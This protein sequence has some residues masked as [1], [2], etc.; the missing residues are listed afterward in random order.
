MDPVTPKSRW[1]HRNGNVYTVL[2]IAN[3]ASENEERYPK[4]VVYQGENGNIWSRPLSDWHRSMTFLPVIR[5]YSYK[6]KKSFE[7]DTPFITLEQ[8]QEMQLE[9]GTQMYGCPN[10][11]SSLPTFHPGYKVKVAGKDEKEIQPHVHQMVDNGSGRCYTSTKC[12][13]CGAIYV[14][15]S[16]D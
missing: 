7:I 15:D 5:V 9:I 4:T 8:A 6:L 3:H 14:C 16:S 12:N 10:A 1:K 13:I 11:G 2:F